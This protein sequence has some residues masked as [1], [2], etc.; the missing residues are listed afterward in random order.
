MLVRT[1]IQIDEG[2]MARIR[3]LVGPRK[4]NRFI[5]D[6]LAEKVASLE[7]QRILELMKEGYLAERIEQAELIDDWA[8]TET[9]GWPEW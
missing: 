7:Q 1:T 2:L 4:L 6:T 9:E 5:N 3:P 8:V